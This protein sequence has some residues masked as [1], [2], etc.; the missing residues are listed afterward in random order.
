VAKVKLV[1]Q[2]RKTSLVSGI[3]F[4]LAALLRRIRLLPIMFLCCLAIAAAQTKDANSVVLLGANGAP[5]HT[6]TLLD[7]MT[8]FL[9]SHNIKVKQA[10]DHSKS[11]TQLV[12]VAKSSG[13]KNLLY[14]TVS[15]LAVHQRPSFTAQCFDVDGKLLWKEE[16]A[17]GLSF[18]LDAAAKKL[19]ENMKKKLTA[20]LGDLAQ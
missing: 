19:G 8:D 3:P 4:L 2:A 10:D 18:S 1:D 15:G 13:A 7:D 12:E 17:A 5:P 14:F 9:S 20:H 11:R 16:A 6:Q